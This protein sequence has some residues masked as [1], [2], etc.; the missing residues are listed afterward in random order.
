MNMIMNTN[1]Q[2]YLVDVKLEYGVVIEV[3]AKSKNDAKKEIIKFLENNLVEI[4]MNKYEY[5]IRNWCERD[6]EIHSI[7]QTMFRDDD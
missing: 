7:C 2:F 3:F 5:Q 1:K 4:E 6:Y